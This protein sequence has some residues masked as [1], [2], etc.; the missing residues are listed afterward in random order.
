MMDLV[1][2]T[3]DRVPSISFTRKVEDDC[4][5]SKR[6]KVINGTAVLSQIPLIS[7]CKPTGPT[8]IYNVA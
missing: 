3:P 4:K 6:K 8:P 5:I 2:K 7:L 1:K